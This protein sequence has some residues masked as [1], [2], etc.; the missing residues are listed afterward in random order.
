MSNTLKGMLTGVGIASSLILILL[1]F[2]SVVAGYAVIITL[3]ALIGALIG[4]L[5]NM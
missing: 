3:C 5:L 1:I 4:K 2:G